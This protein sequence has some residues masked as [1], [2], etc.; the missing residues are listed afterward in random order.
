[1]LREWSA[2]PIRYVLQYVRMPQVHAPYTE[3]TCLKALWLKCG[4]PTLGGLLVNGGLF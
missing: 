4:L 2:G 1:M 3:D